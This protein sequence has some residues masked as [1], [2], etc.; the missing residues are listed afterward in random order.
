MAKSLGELK[1]T[2][3]LPKLVISGLAAPP[4]KAICEIEPSLWSAAS[5]LPLPSTARPLLPESALTTETTPP[6]AI[7]KIRA[8]GIMLL[9]VISEK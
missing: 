5:R 6:G 1:R 8:G 9:P 4:G 7:F 2:G 3:G